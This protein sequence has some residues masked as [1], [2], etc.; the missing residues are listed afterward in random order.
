MHT[1][2]MRIVVIVSAMIAFVLAFTAGVFVFAPRTSH[3]APSLW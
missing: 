3:A 2:R 1:R